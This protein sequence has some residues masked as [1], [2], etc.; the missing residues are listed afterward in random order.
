MQTTIY[1][2]MWQKAE[3]GQ[4]P[5]HVGSIVYT[6]PSEGNRQEYFAT[7]EYRN[8]YLGAPLDPVH[9]NYQQAGTR[10]F[11][12][13][14]ELLA[15]GALHRVFS[16][17]LPGSWGKRK[18]AE[19]VPETKGL[20]EA[21]L[22][23]WMSKAG[24]T[25]GAMLFFTKLPDDERPLTSLAEVDD[26]RIKTYA[27]LTQLAQQ[28][29]D[30]QLAAS[31]IH[32]G[33]RAK[34]TYFDAK[35]EVGPSGMHYIA[36]FNQYNDAYNNSRVERVMI[37]M[38][39][40]AGINTVTAK[41]IRVMNEG[42]HVADIYLTERYDR[43]TD[44]DGFDN[45]VHRISMLSMCDHEIVASQDKGD[46]LNIVDVIRR[47]SGKPEEDVEEMFRRMIFNVGVNNT[48]DHMKNTEMCVQPDGTWRLS[49][50]FDIMPNKD[51][52]IHTATMAGLSN[53]S[54]SDDFIRRTAEKF[55]IPHQ[56]AREI[57]DKVVEVLI[58]WKVYAKQEGLADRDTAY[59]QAA[60][61][62][63]GKK[64]HS[65]MGPGTSPDPI[66]IIRSPGQELKSAAPLPSGTTPGLKR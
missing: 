32:G 35:G 31:L 23:A 8:T 2:A 34:T 30:A 26:V 5:V 51:A 10:L 24:R 41:V 1:V 62:Q 19:V 18:L 13:P 56:K 50:A 28:L 59:I 12:V 20:N 43:F 25:S 64:Y 44:S 37:A 7:F 53:G 36:K 16:D 14:K 9:L 46:Y 17:S 22:L 49:P 42:V 55:G 6:E 57:R 58:Q 47:V 52:Y 33:A 11:P 21:Q 65:M 66:A 15:A 38:A 29:N 40:A 61:D 4:R 3:T 54:L 27:A 45:R 63:S 39:G 60:L 48:D